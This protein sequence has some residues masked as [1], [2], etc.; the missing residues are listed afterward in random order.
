MAFQANPRLVWEWY[1]W[2]RGFMS[3]CRPN[4][5]HYAL[6]D[7]ESAFPD[8]TVVTQNVDGLHQEAGSSEVIELHGN[9]WRVR[10]TKCAY[11]TYSRETPL[12]ELPPICPDCGGYLRPDV[13]WFGE[14]LSGDAI[15]KAF[16]LASGAEAILVVGTSANVHPA[17]SLPY[18]TAQ[19]GGLI[20]EVNPDPTP[21]TR[22]ASFSLRGKAGEVLPELVKQVLES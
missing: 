4:P 5:A 17:A 22:F 10:C 21:L 12:P 9:I 19:N 2:R 13:V 18:F 16:H 3:K 7:L 15:E 20:I 8:L 6:H 14:S 1:D 11:S